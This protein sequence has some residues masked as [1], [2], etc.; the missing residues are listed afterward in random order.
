M[1]LNVVVSDQFFFN[2]MFNGA[3]IKYWPTELEMADLVWVVREI[4]HMNEIAKQITVI[5]INHA[6]NL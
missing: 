5:F 6:A 1:R 2:R 3:E 4:R